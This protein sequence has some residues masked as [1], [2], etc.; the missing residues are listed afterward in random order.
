MNIPSVLHRRLLPLLL[1]LLASP[2]VVLQAQVDP[3]LI[4]SV[5]ILPNTTMTTTF[6][7]PLMNGETKNVYEGTTVT[8]RFS[9]P[10]VPANTTYS[11]DVATLTAGS[12]IPTDGNSMSSFPLNAGSELAQAGTDYTATNATLTFSSGATGGGPRTA[13]FT[14]TTIPDTVPE[15]HEDI[16]IYARNWRQSS[17][18]PDTIFQRPAYHFITAT[19]IDDDLPA[20]AGDYTY[21]DEISTI[22]IPGANNT[23]NDLKLDSSGRAVIVGDFT[24][25]NGSPRNS[26][27]RVATDGRV[28]SS[29]NPN[30]GANSFVSTLEFDASGRILI[31]GGFTSFDG[32]GRN[33][34][35]RLSSAGGLDA[36]FNPGTGADAPIR[37]LALDSTGNILA[38]GEFTLF[39][40]TARNRVVRLDSSGNV[41]VTFNPGTGADGPIRAILVQADGKIVIGGDFTSF[42]GVAR[43]RIARLNTDGSLDFTFTPGSGFDNTVFA[44]D[45]D[46]NQRIL[47]GGSFTSADGTARGRIARLATDGTLDTTFNPGLGSAGG[48][49][50]T[51]FM[52]QQAV[53]MPTGGENRVLVGGLFTSYNQV[54]RRNF[55]RLYEDG[56]VDTEFLDR[57]YNKSAG[58]RQLQPPNS[59][60]IT[61]ADVDSSGNI[62]VG[63]FFDTVGGWDLDDSGPATSNPGPIQTTGFNSATTATESDTYPKIDQSGTQIRRNYAKLIGGTTPG[64]GQVDI[65][66]PLYEIGE[67]ASRNGDNAAIT[68]QR[69]R[70]SLGAIRATFNIIE[71]NATSGVDFTQQSPG[72]GT[73]GNLTWGFAGEGSVD[74]GGVLADGTSGTENNVFLFNITDDVL[75]EGNEDFRIVLTNPASVTGSIELPRFDTRTAGSADW[76]LS[77]AVIP[78]GQNFQLV[79]HRLMN[80]TPVL[81][82]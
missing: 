31:G 70:G 22:T 16:M 50:N 1:L 56:T 62:L 11:L 57:A 20:G 25:V 10:N 80:G 15:F 18:V 48:A 51:V 4:T 79:N 53:G 45:L 63:G 55:I 21:N 78:D 67:F 75:V 71:L 64:P 8:F 6:P 34:I 76:L 5:T 13:D 28:D 74:S 14:V 24:A 37:D 60:F 33:R 73:I 23:V 32:T 58:F 7:G 12:S 81:F 40:G 66:S 69:Q 42:N 3:P 77:G 65:I 54:F 9:V 72:S 61:A 43:N 2:A 38:V 29:F 19:I 30:S 44:L 17:S 35:A 27:A 36:T 59:S 46:N 52:V 68:Y 41:D 47:A 26:I 49:N 82:E 39:N